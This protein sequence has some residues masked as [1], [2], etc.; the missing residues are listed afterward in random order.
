M[1][2]AGWIGR[3][4]DLVGGL[5]E[6][7]GVRPRSDEDTL[8]LARAYGRG[9]G[10]AEREPGAGGAAAVVQGDERG[11]AHQG[12][13]AGPPRDL[14]EGAARPGRQPGHAN[15]GQELVGRQRRGEDP[16][17][18]LLGRKRPPAATPDGGHLGLQR[19][20]HGR[21]LGGRIGVSE[22]APESA[23]VTD[24]QVADHPTRLGKDR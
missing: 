23:S 22:A 24:G 16:R 7:P 1:D 10:A 4:R 2:V 20:H 3:R 13:V 14:D 5:V 9:A 6:R 8:G 19:H 12:E 15:L 11:D 21:Q 17:E 18:E